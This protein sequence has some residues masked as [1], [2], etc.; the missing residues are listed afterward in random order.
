MSELV[1]VLLGEKTLVKINNDLK[2]I[3][4]INKLY[5][6]ILLNE[7]CDNC[8]FKNNHTKKILPIINSSADVMIITENASQSEINA[9]QL[10]SDPKGKTL[11]GFLGKLDTDI[12]DIYITPITKC[13]SK[14]IQFN[15]ALR[16]AS[17]YILNEVAF[18]KPKL[19]VTIGEL[20]MKIIKSIYFD[21][22]NHQDLKLATERKEIHKLTKD[23]STIEGLDMPINFVHTISPKNILNANGEMQSKLKK[24]LWHDLKIIDKFK[25]ALDKEKSA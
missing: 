22:P 5:K 2:E 15:T 9:E 13:Y 17:K 24:V 20:P 16:C 18:I 10:L 4:S 11:L 8:E 7:A 21:I 1:E 6:D 3:N 14:E 25:A 12:K 19:I 23:I